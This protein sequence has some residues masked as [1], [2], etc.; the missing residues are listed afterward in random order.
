MKKITLSLLLSVF[1]FLGY[2]QDTINYVWKRQPFKVSKIAF[3]DTLFLSAESPY[4]QYGTSFVI[5]STSDGRFYFKSGYSINDSLTQIRSELSDSTSSIRTAL[6]D[7][8][9]LLRGDISDT[10]DVLR[11]ELT[12]TA[13]AIRD[14][15]YWEV[16]SDNS[17]GYLKP[18]S[19][20]IDTVFIGSSSGESRKVKTVLQVSGQFSENMFTVNQGVNT[21]TT[22]NAANGNKVLIQTNASEAINITSITNFAV[23]SDID[24][25]VAESSSLRIDPADFT[26]AGQLLK[27]EEGSA[28]EIILDEYDIISIQCVEENLFYVRFIQSNQ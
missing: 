23:G 28:T 2:S 21:D 4:S 6:S 3:A 19:T 16:G 18:N 8:I 13:S 25:H 5:D 24:F 27:T 26:A 12:D 9:T 20:L 7:S 11:G 22:Y 1:C 10:A 14:L 17:S 15:I